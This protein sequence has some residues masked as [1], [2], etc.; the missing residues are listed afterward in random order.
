LE[1]YRIKANLLYKNSAFPENSYNPPHTDDVKS[2]FKSVVYYVNDS[3]GDT[4]L[5]NESF[6]GQQLKNV[7]VTEKCKPKRGNFFAFDS[8]RFHASTPPRINDRR[9]VINFILRYA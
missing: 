1:I 7:T 9:M 5:F 2:N 6:T 8:N 4:I 3:D